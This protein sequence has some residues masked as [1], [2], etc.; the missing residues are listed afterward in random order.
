MN[1]VGNSQL[2]S[3]CISNLDLNDRARRKVALFLD[4]KCHGKLSCTVQYV[5]GGLSTFLLCTLLS[6]GN[7]GRDQDNTHPT[8]S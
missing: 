7:D 2:S 3:A 6:W 4:L 8:R 1:S 5:A